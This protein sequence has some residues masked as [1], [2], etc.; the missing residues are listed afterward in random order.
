MRFRGVGHVGVE[1]IEELRRGYR[2]DVAMEDSGVSV[3]SD[4]WSG[5]FCNRGPA[6]DITRMGRWRGMRR[7]LHYASSPS[8]GNKKIFQVKKLRVG[9]K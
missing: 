9:E 2:E 5:I 8:E 6:G 1:N 3:N 4:L 7:S